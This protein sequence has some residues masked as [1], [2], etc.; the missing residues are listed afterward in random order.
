MRTMTRNRCAAEGSAAFILEPANMP[1]LTR[2][3]ECMGRVLS[4]LQTGMPGVCAIY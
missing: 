1:T 3:T 2:D 4:Q